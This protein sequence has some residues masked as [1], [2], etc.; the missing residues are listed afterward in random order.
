[1]YPWDKLGHPGAFFRP[2]V[3]SFQPSLL[4][5]Q[6]FLQPSRVCWDA[7]IVEICWDML[8]KG[9]S[10][11]SLPLILVNAYYII[12]MTCLIT[13]DW[14]DSIKSTTECGSLIAM[15]YGNFG[16]AR[17]PG[18][19]IWVQQRRYCY[20]NFEGRV[21]KIQMKY[22]SLPDSHW[23]TDFLEQYCIYIY[24]SVCVCVFDEHW[25][26]W[27]ILW[28]QRITEISHSFPWQP[29]TSAVKTR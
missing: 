4:V 25:H 5:V 24:I 11:R 12:I 26:V 15:W 17:Q 27:H 21:L 2:M 6:E 14:G 3:R 19:W 13:I 16:D 10:E 20:T 8:L 23:P 9:C 1:M 28:S 22:Q 7:T 18:R 29:W